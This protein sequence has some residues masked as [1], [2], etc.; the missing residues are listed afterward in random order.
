M[1]SRAL[2]RSPAS[3]FCDTCD[4]QVT[5][6]ADGLVIW[7]DPSQGGGGR[8][9]HDFKIVHKGRCDPQVEAGYTLSLG[10]GRFTGPDGLT[11]LLSWLSAG[12]LQGGGRPRIAPQDLDSYVDLV[13]R[14][15]VPGYEQARRRFGDPGVRKRY[16]ASDETLP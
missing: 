13:R 4:G 9:F 12:P 2:P 6:P 15:Q 8:A 14:V 3:W 16:A 11:L 5:D 1:T 7:R 10:L